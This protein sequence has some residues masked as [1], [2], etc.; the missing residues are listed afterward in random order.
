MKRVGKIFIFIAFCLLFVFSKQS[1]L[2]AQNKLPGDFV[3]DDTKYAEEKV[4]EY[5][6][7]VVEEQRAQEDFLEAKE[8]EKAA[9]EGI[10]QAAATQD[11]QKLQEAND[12]YFALGKKTDEA[13]KK[14]QQAQGKTGMK[15][16]SAERALTNAED[17]TQHW[18]EW[19]KKQ[20]LASPRPL[21]EE[22]LND[23]RAQLKEDKAAISAAE[24]GKKPGVDLKEKGVSQ[25]PQD[26]QPS[27]ASAKETSL[28]AKDEELIR[29]SQPFQTQKAKKQAY[30]DYLAGEITYQDYLKI[31]DEGEAGKAKREQ[32]LERRQEEGKLKKEEKLKKEAEEKAKYE[33]PVEPPLDIV[34]SMEEGVN[35]VIERIHEE[36]KKLGQ[37]DNDLE[38]LKRLAERKPDPAKKEEITKK[39][40]A[41]EG[42]RQSQVLKIEN[43]EK[44]KTDKAEALRQIMHLRH[45]KQPTQPG[46]SDMDKPILT[47]QEGREDEEYLL[48]RINDLTNQLLVEKDYLK[49]AEYWQECYPGP[50]SQASV[51]DAKNTV[52]ELEGQIAN[53]KRDLNSLYKKAGKPERW[54]T[55][56]QKQPEVQTIYD[57]K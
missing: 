43:L 54:D 33:L 23:V 30:D 15:R 31:A 50:D 44:E 28:Q 24:K 13:K 9:L 14:Y 26:I 20:G 4:S 3:A 5:R 1:S 51:E 48:G 55:G 41:L 16:S 21:W 57:A 29:V 18:D 52:A 25:K 56:N 17:T 38:E 2:F 12:K 34:K 35:S 42:E 11:K 8:T 36:R 22:K 47:P 7:A 19:F 45:Q 46:S 32:Q 53:I 27:P 40:E 37:I 39:R 49:K 6:Q 10:R